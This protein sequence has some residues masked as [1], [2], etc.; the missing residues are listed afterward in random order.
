MENQEPTPEITLKNIS[1]LRTGQLEEHADKMARDMKFFSVVYILQSAL[2]CLTIVGAIIGIPMI[3][4]HIKLMESADSYRKFVKSNDFFH[5][6]KAFE[7]QRKFF[8][9]YKVLIIC[10]IIFLILYIGVM[11]YLFSLGF[12][13]MPRDFA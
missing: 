13:S 5:L 2:L 9:F 8:F 1:I 10:L 4:Y 11:V 3:I 12:M 6:N 7:N